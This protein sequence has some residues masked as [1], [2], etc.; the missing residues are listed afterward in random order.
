M[1]VCVCVCVCV[2]N[3]SPR[4][5]SEKDHVIHMNNIHFETSLT[6]LTSEK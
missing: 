1:S 5:N 4:L 6:E 2:Y 3:V